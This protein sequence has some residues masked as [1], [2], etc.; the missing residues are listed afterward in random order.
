[1]KKNQ[2]IKGVVTQSTDIPNMP[3]KCIIIFAIIPKKPCNYVHKRLKMK[4]KNNQRINYNIPW[5][6][7]KLL[8]AMRRPKK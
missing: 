7:K 4:K 1:M 6:N 8:G 5:V 3:T 2:I